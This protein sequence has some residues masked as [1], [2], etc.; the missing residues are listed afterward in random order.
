MTSLTRDPLLTAA[1]ALLL[2][3]MA[4]LC[5]AGVVI[6]GVIPVVLVAHG[7][8]TAKLAEA[9]PGVD[10]WQAIGAII[11]LLVLA[12]VLLALVFQSLRLLKHIVDTVG[13]GDPF[14]P[15]NAR[16]LTQMA[17]LVLAVQVVTLPMGAIGLWIGSVVKD[18]HVHTDAGISGNGL[19]LM[20]VLF[21]LA[22]VFRQGAAM[23]EE[24]E[25]T[26]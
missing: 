15:A 24:L 17:W 11:A 14:V 7:Q 1:K 4:V 6:V 21:I 16:R 9:M 8:V 25:G 20:L 12:F 2:V 18:V 13:E 5:F 10:P 3:L 22:R 26:G 23:R 19:L